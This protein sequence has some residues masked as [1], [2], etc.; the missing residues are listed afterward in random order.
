MPN[1]SFYQIHAKANQGDNTKAAA[2]IM[3]YSPI[4][5]SWWEETVDAKSFIDDLNALNVDEITVRISSIGGSVADGIAIY[6]ALKRHKAHITTCNDGVAYSI[7]G[8]ILMAGDTV[9]MAE[10]A[11]FMIH[12][13]WTY[14]DGN[15]AQLRQVADMLDSWS[16]AMASSYAN[17]SGKSKEEI[18]A[19]LTD[20][21]DHFFTAAEA[22]AEGFVDEITN[23]LAIAAS[24]DRDSLL[25]NMR[26]V[27]NAA[28]TVAAATQPQEKIMPGNQPAA[29]EPTAID[30]NEI[31][32]KAASEA[33]AKDNQRRKD[34]ESSFGKFADRDGVS[35]LMK[36]CQDD[37]AITVEAANRKLLEFLGSQQQP[38]AGR[39]VTV[40]DVNDKVEEGIV[41]AIMARAAVPGVK[42][43]ASNPWRGMRLMDLARDRLVA[44]GVNTKGMDQRKLVA[45]AFTQGTSD[46][47][48]LLENA[49]HKSLQT[50]YAVAPDTWSRFCKTGSVS[51]FREHSR[52]RVGSIGNLDVVGESGEY[53]NKTIP[54]GEKGSLTA[55]TKGNIIN[56]TRQAII[57]D[58][59]DAF[60]GLAVSLG[61]AA[62]R[63]IERDVYALFALNGG[64]G[65]TME[66]GQ[67][68]FHSTHLNLATTGGVPSV[69][70]IESSR[71]AMASQKDVGGNDFL[72]L[73]PSFWVGPI[74]IGGAARAAN[75][76]EY[77]PDANNKLQRTNIVRG[78]F[79]DVIDTPRLEGNPWYLFA[80]PNDAP[81][82]EVAFL[83]GIQEPYMEMEEGFDVDGARWKVRLD[84][85]VGAIDFR[86]AVRNAGA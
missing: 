42:A 60:I 81:V 24:I 56:L 14:A 33:L 22:M 1:K 53:T 62:K 54:D 86:G 23:G 18:L 64:F 59:L 73:R 36:Q 61:R 77:D 39:I 84:F 74:G 7:A 65:P 78:L 20:G 49:L 50:A 3:I 28:P 79:T 68:L 25:A 66:D 76:S 67:P 47:P 12:A 26:N 11:H 2:E 71:V 15:A 17:K 41:N 13:P 30:T 31:Q 9:Q 34:I 58:D 48:V 6:N 75:Q 10:N 27:F 32:A 38:V 35:A 4:G 46:F 40:H 69:T 16:T 85:A 5:S 37:Q 57:N 45:A 70:T 72:D 80:D 83:D 51:D 82:I 21:Q 8:L 19:Y 44:A 29:A 52:Y 63:T 55:K 43:D